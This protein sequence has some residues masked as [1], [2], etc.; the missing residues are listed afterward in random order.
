[1]ALVFKR[2]VQIFV[3]I[4]LFIVC[5]AITLQYKSVTKN[6]DAGISEVRRTQELETQLLNANG[7]IINLKKENMVLK[8]DLDIYRQDAATKD[9]GSSALKQELEKAHLIMGIT[10]VSGSGIEIS[11][12]DS[13]AA[14]GQSDSTDIVHDR[15]LRDVVNELYNAGAE[16]ISINSERIVATTSIRCVGS[17]IMINE[18]RCSSPFVIK[19]IGDSASLES[20]L[21]IRGGVLDVLKLYNIQVNVTK[22]DKVKIGK[23]TGH[24]SFTYAKTEK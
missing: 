7:E 9:S 12:A 22:S 15:D 2:K 20:A 14:K 16:A 13:V 5:F 8:S 1:M 6:S 11:L 21:T 4:I 18:K 23:Y 24:M 17:T 3:A 10:D 19:A